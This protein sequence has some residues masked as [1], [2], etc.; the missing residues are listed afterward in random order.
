MAMNIEKDRKEIKKDFMYF[1][2]GKLRTTFIITSINTC[3]NL[4]KQY[5]LRHSTLLSGIKIKKA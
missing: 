2:N 3:Q 1:C 5:F 4:P